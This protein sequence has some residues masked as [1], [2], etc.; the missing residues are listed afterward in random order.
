MAG[1]K[2]YMTNY[3]EL[4]R[5]KSFFSEKMAKQLVRSQKS[6]ILNLDNNNS[7]YN[8]YSKNSKFLGYSLKIDKFVIT[9]K[10]FTKIRLVSGL[11]QLKDSN[12]DLFKLNRELEKLKSNEDN[13]KP[14]TLLNPVRGGYKSL[15]GDFRGFLPERHLKFALKEALS[16]FFISNLENCS[17]PNRLKRLKFLNNWVNLN[18]GKFGLSKDSLFFKRF[19]FLTANYKINSNIERFRKKRISLN[20]IFFFNKRLLNSYSLKNNKDKNLLKKKKLM[21][22]YEKDRSGEKKTRKSFDKPKNFFKR[23]ADSV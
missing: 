11:S 3:F 13:F 1:S 18:V 5:N 6:D 8:S 12:F 9:N 23:K 20:T 19:S 16:K 15:A 14:I 22:L 21:K 7:L 2:Y 10:F 17:D 4:L